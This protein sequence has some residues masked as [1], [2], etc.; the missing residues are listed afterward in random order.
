MIMSIVGARPQFVKLAPLSKRLRL[1]FKE[2]I[3]H[4]GQHYDKNMSQ[5][6]FE[7]LQIP[8]PDY[9]LSVQAT[10]H[11]EQ[12]AAM[13]NA[14]EQVMLIEKPKLV[15]IF[16]DTNSTLAG[17]LAASKLSI[18]VLH[19]EAGLRS[20]NREMPE[21][22]NRIIADRLSD[23]LFVPTPVAME[24]LVKEGMHEKAWLTGD[25]MV[26]SINDSLFLP[27]NSNERISYLIN[28]PYNLLTLHRPVNVDD[29]L[30]LLQI[31]SHLNKLNQRI[32]FPV[33]PRTQRKL[34]GLVNK[35]ELRN[36]EF[37]EPQGYLD[38]IT[39]QQHAKKIITD[40][41]GIQKEAYIL[42][43]PCITLRKET[44][45]TETAK[46]GWNLLLDINDTQLVEKIDMRPSAC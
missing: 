16:G 2:V 33:H 38:F 7:Q 17:S 8:A 31:L 37:I 28:E 3:V 12:T 20:F 1:L 24:N 45:W 43:I 29:S 5:L 46:V 22:I 15:I 26:D 39:L 42:N 25:I 10:N 9:N 32:L 18:P 44:E 21:E 19:V 40:S 41:G 30:Q 35:G 34:A 27:Y 36:I 23:Y 4:T 14:L 11:G 6:F 13:L